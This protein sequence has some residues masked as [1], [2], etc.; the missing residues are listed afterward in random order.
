MLGK[1]VYQFNN[2]NLATS[3]V[4]LHKDAKTPKTFFLIKD[5]IYSKNCL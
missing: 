2:Y 3:F 5:F 4:L 1:V